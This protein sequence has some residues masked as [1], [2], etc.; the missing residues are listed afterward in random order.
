[1]KIVAVNAPPAISI[2]GLT[3][4]SLS[5]PALDRFDLTATSWR[6]S[7]VPASSFGILQ[8]R[9]PSVEAACLF[10][11]FAATLID[12]TSTRPSRVNVIGTLTSVFILAFSVL[13]R[14]AFWRIFLCPF[15]SMAAS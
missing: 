14:V 8:A 6:I 13:R 1:M 5:T 15:S 2:R 11:A 10:P 9:T 3:K 4:R 7:G 12:A